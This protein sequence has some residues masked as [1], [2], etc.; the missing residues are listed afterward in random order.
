MSITPGKFGELFKSYLVKQI[1]NEPI[2][3]TAPIVF[4]ERITDFLSLVI[5][6][7]IGA[8]I[9]DYG[10]EIT[11]I[12]GIVLILGII[13]ISNRS[14]ASFIIKIFSR[15]KILG[16]HTKSIQT[17]YE[18]SYKL[19]ALVPLVKMTSLSI[20]SWGFECAGYYL[21]LKSFSVEVS[22][23][24]ASFA[25]AFATIVGAVSM[26]PGGLGVT[27]GSLSY[28]VISQGYTKEIA[29][30]STFI[31]RVVTLWF[32]VLIGVISVIIYQNKF[33]KIEFELNAN[34][35]Q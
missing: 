9:F 6:S 17:A 28:L 29:F 30:A 24:W 2:S 13:I 8:Y 19:L 22:F 12:I 7:L 14:I 16:K 34:S 11:V 33:G 27:E 18:S 10:R 26:L 23:V 20:I 15:N 3:K 32:A 4:A 5:I 35:N 31:V 25:Y 1:N 21:I